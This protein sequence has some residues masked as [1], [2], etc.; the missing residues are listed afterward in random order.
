M[1]PAYAIR[2]RWFALIV[3]LMVGSV[4]AV[5]AEGSIERLLDV[6]GLRHTLEQLPTVIL[7]TLD[8][9]QPDIDI[10]P[11]IRV[12]MKDAARQAFGV[13]ALLSTARNHLQ[14][15]LSEPQ[16]ISAIAFFET[17]L[18]RRLTRLEREL[19]DPSVAGVFES[20]VR[21]LATRPPGHPRLKLIEAYDAATGSSE[22]V[23]AVMESTALAVALGL[24]ASQPRQAQLPSQDLRRRIREALPEIETQARLHVMASVLFTY[25]GLDDADFASYVRF[26]EAPEGAGYARASA[27]LFQRIMTESM[28][29]LMQA[30]PMAIERVRGSAR[31]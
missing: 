4:P 14:S 18:G 29:R 25:R 26:L 17:P 16:L 8:A 5:R 22:A 28:G 20:Y 6:S 3:L 19:A 1:I 27:Q 30:L 2:F 21:D 23:M 7:T 31:I 9:P 24:N 11:Q 12:A 13:G 10:L 15:S